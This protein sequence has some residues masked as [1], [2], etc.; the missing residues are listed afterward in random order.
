MSPA[1]QLSS[2]EDPLTVHL[3]LLYCSLHYKE[4][5]VRKINQRGL[6][7]ISMYETNVV[8]VVLMREELEVPEREEEEEEEE[9]YRERLIK[10]RGKVEAIVRVIKSLSLECGYR[11]LGTLE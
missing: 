7:P 1:A 5:L 9:D 10:V 8:K 4:Y 3:F 11:R 2:T 6:D